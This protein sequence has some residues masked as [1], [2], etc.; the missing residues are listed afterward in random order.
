MRRWFFWPYWRIG[1]LEQYDARLWRLKLSLVSAVTSADRTD[2]VALGLL[3]LPSLTRFRRVQFTNRF[4]ERPLDLRF[5]HLFRALL[6]GDFG[7]R[8]VP[9]AAG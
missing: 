9:I 2:Y 6:V 7:Q 8:G 1:A 3:R 5:L 4:T